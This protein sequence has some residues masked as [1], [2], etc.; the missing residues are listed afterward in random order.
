VGWVSGGEWGCVWWVGK[1]SGVGVAV[2]GDGAERMG[3]WSQCVGV[4]S[5][6]VGVWS[7]CVAFPSQ[8]GPEFRLYTVM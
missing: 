3:V 4:W 1:E 5:R 7:G 2:V 6:C 8:M